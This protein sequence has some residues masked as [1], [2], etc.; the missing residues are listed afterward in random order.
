[1]MWMGEAVP[2][3]REGEGGLDRRTSSGRVTEEVS[4]DK[5]RKWQEGW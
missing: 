4:V 3:T 5:Q 1:M 2:R